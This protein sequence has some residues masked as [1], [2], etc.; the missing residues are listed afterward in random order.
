[1]T[2]R[3]TKTEFELRLKNLTRKGEPTI[4][5]TPLAILRAFDISGKPFF[6]EYSEANF[7]LA[8]NKILPSNGYIIEGHFSEFDK[9]T[10]L[11]YEIKPISFTYYWIRL[12]PILAF[13]FFN[14]VLLFSLK[15]F[16]WNIILTIN[17]IL[18]LMTFVA[19]QI[20][21]FQRRAIEARFLEEFDV[22]N[23]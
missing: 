7:R 3:L 22:E 15:T 19:L 9:K 20:D 17:G 10:K 5:G 18:G 14:G 12:V 11:D 8:R 16:Q 1:M 6:G 2:S 21:K 23:Y 13:C 4:M